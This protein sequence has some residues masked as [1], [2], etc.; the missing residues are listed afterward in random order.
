MDLA[1]MSRTKEEKAAEKA[2]YA[3]VPTISEPEVPEYPYGLEIQLEEESLEKLGLECDDFSINSKV[4][5]VCNGEVI[6][7]HESADKRSSNASVSI[8]ITGMAMRVIPNE[9]KATLKD[10]MAVIKGGL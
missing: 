6:R 4:E 5:M 3:E 7:L 10:V 2:K 8:Q 1:D 9:K